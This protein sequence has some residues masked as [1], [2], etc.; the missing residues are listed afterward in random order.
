MINI[1]ESY[2]NFI[3][4]LQELIYTI[5][6]NKKIQAILEYVDIKPGDTLLDLGGNTG[7]ITE[8]YSKN[9]KEVVIVEPNHNIVE[10]GR[11]RRQHIKFVAGKAENIPLP[12]NYFDKVVASASF[13]YFPNQDAALDEIKRVLKPDGKTIILEIDPNTP[14]GKRL[15]FFETLFHTGAKLYQPSQLSKKIQEHD[16]EVLSIDSTN[17]GYFLTA[18]KSRQKKQM[19]N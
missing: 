11:A 14:R 4:K 17:F 3:V 1:G 8:A 2:N 18:V 6:S 12:D 5:G 16:L 10:Y 7:K 15:K 19:A 9:C 13:H